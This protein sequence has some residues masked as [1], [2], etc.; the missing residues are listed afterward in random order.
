MRLLHITTLRLSLLAAALLTLWSVLFYVGLMD[1]VN[2]EV[3]DSLEDYAEVIMRRSLRGEP[4]PII[5]NG[6]NNYYYQRIVSEDYAASHPALS[7]TDRDVYIEAK[8]E[9]EPARVVSYIYMRQDGRYVRLEVATPHIDKADLRHAIAAWIGILYGL[10]LLSIVLVNVVGLRR[11]MRPLRRLLNWIQDYRLGQSNKPLD[12]PTHIDEFRQLTDV[13]EESFR[14][15]QRLYEE[16]KVFIGNASHEMQTP[17]AI[18]QGRIDYLLEEE[19]LSETQMGELLKVRH[20]LCDL[21]QLNRSLLLLCK[22]ENG[23]LAA[24]RPINLA[25][26]LEAEALE[27][28]PLYAAR[29]ITTRLNLDIPFSI[30]M[31]PTLVTTLLQNLLKN[32]YVHNR[33]KGE[34]R[35]AS[36]TNSLT[37]RNTG[38]PEAL[39]AER[40][41]QRFY[42]TPGRKAS[43][44]LGLALAQAICRRY[45]LTL[46]YRFDAEGYHTFEVRKFESAS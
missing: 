21:S 31:D 39:P 18:C 22:I 6:T 27:L 7:Y 13:V 17:I 34:V 30:E 8:G 45:R 16:Q 24:D 40:I 46:T 26:R 9:T 29:G 32:A 10:L 28:E 4:L 23:Q 33:E 14:R 19:S 41:F 43:S 15:G 38:A 11:T 36:T 25:A 5:G 20:T 1:E 35:L 37:L 44:G 3:D 12:N 2:D 42:H